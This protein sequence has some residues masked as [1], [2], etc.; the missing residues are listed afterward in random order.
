MFAGLCF[1]APPAPTVRARGAEK[2]SARRPCAARPPLFLPPGCALAARLRVPGG[3]PLPARLRSNSGP[4]RC[5]RPRKHAWITEALAQAMAAARCCCHTTESSSGRD[6]AS[7]WRRMSRCSTSTADM[8]RARAPLVPRAVWPR[9]TKRGSVAAEASL[10]APPTSMRRRTSST[11]T[12]RHLMA[13]ASVRCEWS[14][15][16]GACAKSKLLGSSFASPAR[17]VS[18]STMATVSITSRSL[19]VEM[20]PPTPLFNLRCT[21]PRAVVNTA[22]SPPC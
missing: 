21:H 16:A 13:A 1:V 20:P 10:A 17:S 22:P 5:R 18:A 2:P 3:A 15:L 6:S 12:R 9:P 7:A 8:V 11:S 4:L 14:V 19:A